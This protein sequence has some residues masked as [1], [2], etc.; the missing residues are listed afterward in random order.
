MHDENMCIV[1]IQ[2][3]H[4]AWLERNFPD[5]ISV[6]GTDRSFKGLV[7][8]LGELA[9]HS[10][11]MEQGIRGTPEEHLAEMKDAVGDLYIFLNSYCTSQG[12]NLGDII[13]ET[14]DEVKKRD[15]I[16]FP[17]DGLTE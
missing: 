9:H 13:K 1:C 2:E 16:A 17:K 15:W 6:S 4:A 7:E 3:E 11:K 14:W 8:E 5:S 12:W 10:L